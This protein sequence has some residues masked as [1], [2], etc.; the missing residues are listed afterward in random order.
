MRVSWEELAL[1]DSG[2]KVVANLPYSISKPFLRR[3]Y[4]EWR[5]HLTTATLMLQREVAERLIA[6]PGTSAYGPMAIM[7]HLYSDTKIAFNLA[8]GVFHPP[9]EVSSS[10]VHIVLHAEPVL[11]LG[12]E[13]FFWRVVNAAFAQRRKQLANTL[14]VV[15]ADLSL[16][17]ISEPTRPY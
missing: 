8:P 12:N 9:P 11:A 2:V 15:V 13:K 4:E 5:P 3:V 7:A 6:A 14:R 16:I 10:V 1:P 17:H